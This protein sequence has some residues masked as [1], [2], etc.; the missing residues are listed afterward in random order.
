MLLEGG[1]FILSEPQVYFFLD[2]QELPSFFQLK[3][4]WKNLDNLEISQFKELDVGHFGLFLHRNMSLRS[5]IKWNNL[6]IFHI[7]SCQFFL[8]FHFIFSLKS[9]DVFF[10]KNRV[11]FILSRLIEQIRETLYRKVCLII[12]SL[13]LEALRINKW[14]YEAI[15]YP[16]YQRIDHF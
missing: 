15:E 9:G 14:F 10:A 13:L 16:K 7:A 4:L 3:S 11:E 2:T 5:S 8:D 6:D 1:F 12:F